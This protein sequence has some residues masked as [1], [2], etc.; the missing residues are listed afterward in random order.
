MLRT[1]AI[2]AALL[3]GVALSSGPATAQSA[4]PPD[5]E[6][7]L[8]PTD[9]IRLAEAFR[10]ADALGDS[11]WP[12]WH[13][14]PFA[15]LLVTPEREFLLRHPRPSADFRRIGY[16]SLLAS[17]VWERARQF[18]PTLLAT[19]PAVGDVPTI[20]VGRAEQT[21]KRSTGWVLTLLHEHFHQWQMAQ[22]DY[23][24]RV[25]ALG[26]A[27]G[28][29]TG[30]WMLNHPFPYDSAHVQ[31]R[32]ADAWRAVRRVVTDTA[33]REPAIAAL[34]ALRAALS[35]DDRRY[36]DFQMWQEGVARYTEL[37]VARSAATHHRPLDAF[38][39]LPDYEPYARVER[40]LRLGVLG[41]SSVALGER[42]RVAFYPFGA[43]TALM[44]DAVVPR[45]RREYVRAPLSLDEFLR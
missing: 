30:M 19:F 17:D 9:R 12:G 14:A 36:L 22:P 44:L 34:A 32:F 38:A 42:R 3:V 43:M 15:V 35:V 16:D 18:P 1:L 6:A 8:D 28:D 23:F 31:A 20:V 25:A 33:A 40:A 7:A 5:I 45:W 24:G 13:A 41:D 29:S 21:G 37:A 27:R 2:A 11:V 4:P 26:L 10:L 39:A